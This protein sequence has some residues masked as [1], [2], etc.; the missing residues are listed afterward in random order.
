MNVSYK[1]LD[2][3]DPKENLFIYT[4]SGFSFATVSM[5]YLEAKH[6]YHVPLTRNR[7]MCHK[8]LKNCGLSAKLLLSKKPKIVAE[9][10]QKHNQFA[11]MDCLSPCYMPK[12]FGLG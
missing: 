12:L 3:K 9:D 10:Y 8:E 4:H 11:V 1:G 5:M 7:V 2:S 6:M